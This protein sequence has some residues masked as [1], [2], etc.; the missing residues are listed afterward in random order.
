MVVL[1][2]WGEIGT[3]RTVLEIEV[4][5]WCTARGEKFF[6]DVRVSVCVFPGGPLITEQF[7]GP[8]FQIRL[9]DLSSL[10]LIKSE[11]E[12]CAMDGKSWLVCRTYIPK[13][14]QMA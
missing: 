10:L 14:I 5:F 4:D 2:L 9:V 6:R 1:M 11:C 3:M 8:F 13:V 7:G 12:F